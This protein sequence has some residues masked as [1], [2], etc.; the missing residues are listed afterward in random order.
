MLVAAL[1][2]QTGSY[3]SGFLVLVTLAPVSIAL[4]LLPGARTPTPAVKV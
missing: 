4:S 1:R 2:D 3:T